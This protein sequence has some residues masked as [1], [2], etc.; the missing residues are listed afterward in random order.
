[1]ASKLDWL[2][3][4]FKVL[5][6][7]GVPGL[8]IERLSGDL[9]LTKGS[10]YHHFNGMSGY[11]ADLLNH[12]EAQ[13]TSRYIDGVERQGGPGSKLARL[14][15]LVLADEDAGLEI[16]IRAWALQDDGVRAVQERID[17]LRTAYLRT[18]AREAGADEADALARLLYLVLVGA[19]Q[20]VPP[21]PTADLR[22]VY[23]LAMRLLP[24]E[25]L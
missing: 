3:A 22:D 1:M 5:T 13:Y 11:R 17:R 14:L 21:L 12:F 4:G 16:A 7:S 10:F 18:L 6:E 9:G 8:T 15:D 20:V 19:Q 24:K 23:E 25:E 2:E